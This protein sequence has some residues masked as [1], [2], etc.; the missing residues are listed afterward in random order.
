MK[1]VLSSPD[2]NA[3]TNYQT[4]LIL[5][6]NTLC[7]HK[8]CLHLS[9]T[10]HSAFPLCNTGLQRWFHTDMLFFYIVV[11]YS[12]VGMY[13]SRLN[14]SVNDRASDRF[15]YFATVNNAALKAS[16]HTSCHCVC[17]CGRG[18][19]VQSGSVRVKALF[20]TLSYNADDKLYHCFVS[21]LSKCK[22]IYTK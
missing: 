7:T 17:V 18:R 8:G 14:Q 9:P 5:P 6:E 3:V 10:L 16:A 21:T 4:V 11:Q 20:S 2:A 13:H 12:L 22:F 1:C 15:K 19:G